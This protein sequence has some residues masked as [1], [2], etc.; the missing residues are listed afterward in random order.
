L[1]QDEWEETIPNAR[2]GCFVAPAIFG[3]HVRHGERPAEY[4]LLWL[5]AMHARESKPRLLQDDGFS[6]HA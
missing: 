3:L 4:A 1:N 2:R 6:A 5:Y